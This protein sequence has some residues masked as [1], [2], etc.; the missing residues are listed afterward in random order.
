MKKYHLHVNNREKKINSF[1]T[2]EVNMG[3]L[4]FLWKQHKKKKK[5]ENLPNMSNQSRIS[6][7][8]SSTFFYFKKKHT[9]EIVSTGCNVF[10]F[11]ICLFDL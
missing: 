10:L 8:H 4:V 3:L 7:F 6:Y 9:V 2:T 11:S 1:I 5:K